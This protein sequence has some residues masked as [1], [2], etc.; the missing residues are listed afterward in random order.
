MGGGGGWKDEGDRDKKEKDKKQN[1]KQRCVDSQVK[2]IL[3][4]SSDVVGGA[5][6]L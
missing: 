6:K 5:A 2:S 1:K 4:V 3:I